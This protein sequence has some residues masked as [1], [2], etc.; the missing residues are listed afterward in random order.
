MTFLDFEESLTKIETD[1]AKIAA[2]QSL[3]PETKDKECAKLD[4][5][6]QKTLSKIYTRLSPWDKVKVARHALRP[7][8]VDYLDHLVTDFVPLCGDRTYGDDTA[9]LGGMGNFRGRSVMLIGHE[10][11]HDTQSRVA[12]NFG[13]P[14]PEGYRKALRLVKLANQYNLPVLSFIDTP[15]AHPGVGAE[16]RGQSESIAQSTKAF[17]ELQTPSIGL[18]AGEGMSGGAIAIGVCNRMLMLEHSIY[19]VISPEGCA[20]ILWRD[21]GQADQAAKA[22]RLT[23]NDLEA[24]SIVD[25]VIE[26]PV[27]GAHRNRTETMNR[28]GDTIEKHLA[29]LV[30]LSSKEIYTQREARFMAYGIGVKSLGS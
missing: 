28:V 5:K 12:H 11:G 13:M 7:H 24:L 17:I 29:D 15:G 20:S 26:E 6:Y 14:S 1:L 23:S 4:E 30:G 27:G 21:A 3:S 10:K 9:L 8:F 19:S 25:E 22:L 16:A 2:D 18:I